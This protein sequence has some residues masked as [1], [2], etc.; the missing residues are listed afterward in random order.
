[1]QHPADHPERT[2]AGSGSLE[3][4]ATSFRNAAVN[5]IPGWRPWDPSVDARSLGRDGHLTSS[6]GL[7]K[8]WLSA[9]GLG[10]A[11][12]FATTH[13]YS[14]LMHV[15]LRRKARRKCMTSQRLI[16]RRHQV[17]IHKYLDHVSQ[18]TGGPAGVQDVVILVNR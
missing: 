1:M 14:C 17:R 12:T 6:I 7:V 18:P 4:F 3:F 10:T 13:S 9:R 15:L 11:E 8:G 5:G 16:H 2:G